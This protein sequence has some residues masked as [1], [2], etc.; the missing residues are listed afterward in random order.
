MKKISFKTLFQ[1]DNFVRIFALCMAVFCWI[2]ASMTDRSTRTDTITRVPVDLDLQATALSSNLGLNV[3][4]GANTYVDVKING[5]RTIVGSLTA[6][7]L[8]L[9]AK[10]A[11]ITGPGAYDL[12]IVSAVPSSDL[13]YKIVSISPPRVRVKLD[14]LTKVP[15]EIKPVVNGMSMAPGF[16]L[17]DI[18]VNPAQVTITGPQTE[19][20]KIAKCVVTA[21]LTDPLEKPYAYEHPIVLLDAK[22]EPIDPA[23]RHLTLDSSEAQLLIT[24]LKET[25][26]PLEVG[27]RNVPANFPIEELENLRRLSNES[28]AIA[29]P[30]DILENITEIRL[31]YID[32]KGLTT[33]RSYNYEV[34]LPSPADQ[35]IRQDNVTN[36]EV[37]FD[38]ADWDSTSFNVK[39]L[40]LINM[41]VGYDVKLV[42]D[43]LYN[44]EMTGSKRVLEEL[45]ADDILVEIDL[46][47]REMTVGSR[48]F[49]VT[50]SAPDKGLVWAVGDYSVVIQVT[51]SENK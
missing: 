41:P 42:T 12:E 14:R 36:V 13:T 4:E 28:V 18:Y 35:F 31:G 5:L 32:L 43:T 47:E 44:V 38:D 19:I 23:A 8:S 40:Q 6:D 48:K 7:D 20:D 22:G 11:N 3:I 16:T 2:G 34:P 46:S 17:G 45:S 37:T 21:E 33:G 49:P 25:E 24:T 30:A 39:N 26:L 15:F 50:I 51:K 9:T 27:F 29:G 1:N 10:I